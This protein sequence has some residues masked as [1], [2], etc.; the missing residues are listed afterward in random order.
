M[1]D[2]PVGAV[3]APEPVTPAVPKLV[4]AQQAKAAKLAAVNAG[5]KKLD[6]E[7]A[8]KTE[9][10][11]A[12]V[13]TAAA[14]S[15]AKPADPPSTD[16]APA[17][18]EPK[19][20]AKTEEPADDETPDPKTAKAL[21]Q[22]D[23]Q[24]KRFRE[25]QAKAR[26]DFE[27]ERAE[28]ARERAE[29]KKAQGSIDEIAKLAK[30]NPAAALAKLGLSS[31][32]DYEHVARTLVPLTKTGKADPRNKQA[33]EQLTK[34]AALAAQVEDLKKT[35][36]ELRGTFETTA[37]EQQTKAFVEKYLDEAVKAIPAEPTLIG[38]LHAKSPEKARQALLAI[39]Q[40]LEKAN[41]ETPTHAEVIEAYEKYRRE[42]LEEQ[43]VDVDAMLKPKAIEVPKPPPSKTLDPTAV[44]GTRPINGNPTKAE[45][46]AAASKGLQKLWSEQS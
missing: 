19:V 41:D 15:A 28:F 37:K 36:E 44:T 25:E 13:E 21:A 22:I 40:Y 27:L 16:A 45:R 4:Q 39:G 29:F 7:M 24:A 11:E 6:A 2:V 23:K 33:V 17:K 14:G 34:E 43:G 26:A 20:E 10:P 46:L 9:S 3:P 38:K 42:E 32:D 12:S 35:V 30:T 31:E 1:A 18:K 8:T 5:L